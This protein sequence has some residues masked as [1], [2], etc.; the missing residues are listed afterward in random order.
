MR[1]ESGFVVGDVMR[2]YPAT[3]RVFIRHRLHCPGCAFSSFCTIA[4]AAA[5]HN[6]SLPGVLADL[7]RAAGRRGPSE[8][9]PLPIPEG[10]GDEG[11]AN[12]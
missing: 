11:L 7:Q 6:A 12:R 8:V 5:A 10:T 3:I 9:S 1:I 4:Y 2:R